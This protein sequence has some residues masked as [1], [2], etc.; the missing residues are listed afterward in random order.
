M[1]EFQRMYGTIEQCEEAVRAWRWPDGFQCPKCTAKHRTE[2]RRGGR[3]YLQCA[4]CQYQCSL[5]AGTVFASTKLPLTTWFLGM[6]LLTKAKTNLSALELS[7]DLDVSYRSAWLLKHKAMETMRLREQPRQLSGR[8]EIDDA[9]LGGQRSGGKPGRGSENKVPFAAAVQ[10]TES[11]LAIHACLSLRPF[12]NESM[13]EFAASSLALPLTVV[14]D[15]LSCF[16]A[17]AAERAVHDRTVTG[18]GKAAVALPQFRAVN[19]LLG[20]VSK[21]WFITGTSRG[22]GR[23]WR[24]AALR[25]GDKVAAA[26]RDLQTLAALAAEFGSAVLPLELDVTQRDDVIAAIERAAD[27]FGRLDVVACN[28]GY[29]LFATVEE[30]SEAAA[31]RQFETNFFG[32]LW[33]LQAALPIFRQQGAG[34]FLVVS[35][36]AS[37]ITFPNGRSVQRQQVGRRRA[38]RDVGQGNRRLRNQDHADRTRWIRDRLAWQLCTP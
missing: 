17:M 3:L 18:G 35:S 6:H 31:R 25:R 34:H 26:A 22:F 15:G 11:G 37:V 27:H 12:T 23:A 19:T 30:T 10:T 29:G 5:I 14:S 9:Y 13:L 33:T 7:R 24:E 36:L 1:P 4:S 38:V 28:A 21:V 16:V 20:M 2:F 8:V 32:A